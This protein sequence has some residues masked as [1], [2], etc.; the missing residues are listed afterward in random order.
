LVIADNQL[1][2]NAGWDEEILRVELAAVQEEDFDLGLVGFYDEELATIAG[3]AGCTRRA[4][5]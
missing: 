3:S 5:G 4:H 1:A 2:L